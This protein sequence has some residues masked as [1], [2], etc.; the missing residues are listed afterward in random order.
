[1]IQHGPGGLSVI[2]EKYESK[3]FTL[4]AGTTNYNVKTGQSAFVK[5]KHAQH[6][7]IRTDGDITVRLNSTGEDAISLTDG[8]YRLQADGILVT[9]IFIS[10]TPGANVKILLS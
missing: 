10:S 9:N 3:E 2:G 7:I 4:A 8:D 6:V 1:M 5:F